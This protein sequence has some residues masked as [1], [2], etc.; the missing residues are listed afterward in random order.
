MTMPQIPPTPWRYLR[1]LGEALG[2]AALAATLIWQFSKASLN[3]HLD[4]RIGIAVAGAIETVEKKTAENSDKLD[5]VLDK[6]GNM[7]RRLAVQ[8]TQIDAA[9][10]NQKRIMRQLDGIT[11]ILI[12][13]GGRRRMPAE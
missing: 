10:T 8:G 6:V 4:T 2:A 5:G 13:R 3:A 9:E 11:N 1:R 7:D 12:D